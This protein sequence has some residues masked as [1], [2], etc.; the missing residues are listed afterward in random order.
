ML[1]LNDVT[2]IYRTAS[3]EKVTALS[4]VSLSLDKNGLVFIVGQSGSGKTT[5]LNLIGGLDM[6]EQGEILVDEL[7]LG[8]DISLEKYRQNYVG[9][10]FQEY[11]LLENLSVYENIAIAVSGCTKKE[12]NEKI[13]KVLKE[14]DLSGYENR[15]MNELSGGQKQRV[16]IARALAKN[17]S[18]LLCDEPTGNL[19]SHTSKEI[20]DLLKKISLEKTVIVVSHNEELAKEYADRLIRIADGKIVSDQ[21][22]LTERRVNGSGSKTVNNVPFRYKLKLGFKNLFTQKFKTLIAASLL[23]LSLVTVCIM[24]I[25]L[26]YNSERNLAKSLSG[27]K[28]VV[29]LQNNSKSGISNLSERYQIK[30]DLSKY[31]SEDRF[32]DGYRT[33]YGTVFISNNAEINKDFY[34]KQALGNNEAYISDYFIDI[35]IKL[36][37]DYGDLIY[38][39]YEDLLGQEVVYQNMAI[40]KIAGILKTDYKEYMDERGNQKE[41]KITTFEDKKNYIRTYEYKLNYEYNVIYTTLETF[42]R[43]YIGK[44]SSSFRQ[45]EGYQI[46][47]TEADYRANLT[48]IHIYNSNVEVLQYFDNS[49]YLNTTKQ[50][51]SG[52]GVLFNELQDDEIVINGELYNC[53][54]GSNINW[55]EFRMNYQYGIDS[56]N[57]L[58]DKLLN[59]G[60]TIDI[61]I[62]DSNGNTIIDILKKKIVGVNSINK[63]DIDGE[64]IYSV[65]GTKECFSIANTSLAEHYVS[66]LQW[67]TLNNKQKILQDLRSESIVIAGTSAMLIY[68]KEYIISQMSYFL[69]VISVILSILTIISTFNLVNAKIRDNQKEIGILMGIGFNNK[70]IIFIYLFSMLC[71]ILFSFLMTLAIVYLGVHIANLLLQTKP[72]VNIVFFNVDLLTYLTISL[73]GLIIAILSLI[74]LLTLSNKKP[75]DIIKN[76]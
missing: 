38:V 58:M 52:E 43:M 34:V 50:G 69:I 51:N 59:L 16:A 61:T 30:A 7:V 68:E 39:N 49:G 12:L 64:A 17:T 74:P 56:G 33:I 57:H 15:K 28:T 72:F 6:P 13:V 65:Y 66:E 70:D 31:F 23:L 27:E 2:K 32:Y 41:N 42:N 35:V 3:K 22:Y 21:Q 55:E 48:N 44:N 18:V 45:D 29:V 54:F 24:Q 36:N 37:D 1:K 71:M 20:F 40:F 75:I 62:K 73:A 63:K 19:D 9:F 11:N 67:T 25:C 4:N 26:N 14:V 46:C 60:K 5:L 10:V 8:R 53:I 47:T 76:K